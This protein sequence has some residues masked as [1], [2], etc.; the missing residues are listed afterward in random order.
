MNECKKA[1]ILAAGRGSRL[2]GLTEDKPKCL[3]TVGGRTLLEWQMG[4][5]KQCGIE[6]IILV[7]G[8]RSSSFNSWDVIKVHNSDWEKTNMLSSLLCAE[9]EFD[10]ALIVSYSDIIY[11]SEIVKQLQEYPGDAVVAYDKDWHMLWSDRFSDPLLD[12]ETFKIA[13]D[14]RIREIG[15]KPTDVKEIQGQYM[16][17][18]KFTPHAMD[19]IIGWTRKLPSGPD[20]IDM[21]TAIQ[22]LIDSGYPVYGV[23]TK[24][25]WCE[26]DDEKD[27]IVAEDLFSKGLIKGI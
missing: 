17:L 25:R 10:Q 21:T 4:T 8:Y 24:G 27:L 3:N 5:L 9:R 13:E 1:I 7:T 23:C 12:A 22:G 6:D 15:K 16:G 20:K 26:I 14:S 19:N 2:K 18:M 11:C